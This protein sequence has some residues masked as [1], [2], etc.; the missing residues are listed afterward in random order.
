LAELEFSID[1]QA[2]QQALQS[3]RF[4]L[5]N[6]EAPMREIGE[7]YTERVDRRFEQEGPGWSP[8]NPKYRQWKQR[9]PRAIDKILQFSGLLRASVN[10]QVSPDGVV[11]GSDKV[12]ANRQ[13]QTRSFLTPDEEDTRE[14]GAILLAYLR[15][16]TEG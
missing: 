13:A 3:L 9:Q 10:Y 16:H 5:E 15:Q 6:L 14:F 11:I 7:Y 8:L 1:D 2:I 12:Y 4:G